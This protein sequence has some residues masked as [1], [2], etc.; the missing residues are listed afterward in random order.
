MSSELSGLFAKIGFKTDDKSL[1]EATKK[2]KGL[3]KSVDK[4]GKKAL[5]VGKNATSMG[6]RLG[7]VFTASAIGAAL[8]NKD[9]LS[10]AK[11]LGFVDKTGKQSVKNF[12]NMRLAAKRMGSDFTSEASMLQNEITASFEVGASEGFYRFIGQAESVTDA[13]DKIFARLEGKSDIQKRSI[14]QH[15][16]ISG[17]DQNMFLE[18]RAAF[19]KQMAATERAVSYTHLTLP[20]KA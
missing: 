11:S 8:L 5:E 7:K 20:T 6:M 16:G 17:T 4:I 9:L 3:E 2:L 1:A 19:D 14:L 18:G 15:L 13:V 12:D 10:V